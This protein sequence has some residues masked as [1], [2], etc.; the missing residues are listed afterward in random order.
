MPGQF[1]Q[2]E[3]GEPPVTVQIKHRFNATAERV[4]DAWIDPAM[5]GRWMFGP[6]VREEEIL[7]IVA[8]AR[9]GGSFSFLVRRQQ[10]E[11]DHIGDYLEIDRPRRLAFSW[12]VGPALPESRVTIDIAPFE[13]GCELTL[14]HEM[15]RKWADFAERTKGGWSTMLQALEKALR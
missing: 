4:F 9:V 14:T 13:G 15:H 8:D 10:Q 2:G 1:L 11:F 12:G 7:H 6:A 3:G 5:L